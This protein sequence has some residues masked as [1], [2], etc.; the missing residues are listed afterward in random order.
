MKVKELIELLQS[1]DPE[2]EVIIQ[3]DAEGN[4]YSPLADAWEGSY[5]ADSTW[6]GYA[7]IEELTPE[8]E[9]QGYSDWDVKSGVPAIML[10]PVN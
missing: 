3:K 7:G 6:S 10:V 1:V 4:D 5:E 9:A 8:L 2:R